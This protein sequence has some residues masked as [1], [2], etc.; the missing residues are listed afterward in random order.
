MPSVIQTTSSI[1][2]SIASNMALAAKGGGTKI[3]EASH[4]VFSLASLQFPKTGTP[5]CVEPAFFGLIPP[6]T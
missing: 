4:W 2:A 3:T 5:R 6:T 1:S